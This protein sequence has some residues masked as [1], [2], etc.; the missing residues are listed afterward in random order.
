LKEI[1]VLDREVLLAQHAAKQ[2]GL[3]TSHQLAA[4]EF[5][6]KF[7]AAR[8]RSG[9]WTV[10][11]RSV[12]KL[13]SGKPTLVQEELAAVFAFDGTLSH[14]SALRQ[15]RLDCS[16]P[17]Q[18]GVHL[19]IPHGRK[20]AAPPDVTLWRTRDLPS[21]DVCVRG[22]FRFTSL[23]RTVLDLASVLDK[24]WLRATVDACLRKDDNALD[25]IWLTLLGHG[26]GRLGATALRLVLREYQAED[27]LPQSVLESHAMEL[28]LATGRK[29]Q[30]QFTP[31]GFDG[32]VDFAWPERRL[33]LE[34]DGYRY[35]CTRKAFEADHARDLR[36]KLLGWNVVR[37]TWRNVV[38]DR[39]AF[40]NT[41]AQ[42]YAQ[43]A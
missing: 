5:G 13:S 41:A 33:I 27:E 34:L 14:F 19:T 43:A 31:Q 30:L 7:V 26:P 40:M 21:F 1:D 3:V 29:P 28:G 36:L 35:H 12:I 37:F 20:V 10:V 2:L 39:Q 17:E 22:P 38:R 16:P 6:R 32:R 4:M 25:A 8:I 23:G 9:L 11:Q 15:L 42:L 24:G 18:K